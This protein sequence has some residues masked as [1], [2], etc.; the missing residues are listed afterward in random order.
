MEI[1]LAALAD[2]AN[3][4]DTGKL[5]LLGVFGKIGTPIVPARHPMMSLVLMLRASPGEKGSTH[6]IKIKLLDADGQA[7]GPQLEFEV[8]IPEDAPSLSPELQFII[9]LQDLIFPTFGSYHFEILINNSNAATI[10]LVVE[11]IAPAAPDA[12]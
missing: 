1:T 2:A 6:K 9:N 11:A 7:I 4:T 5:N 12:G 10:P 3:R 8:I